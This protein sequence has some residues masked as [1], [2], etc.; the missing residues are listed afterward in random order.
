MASPCSRVAL[1]T[2]A[3]HVW[4]GQGGRCDGHETGRDLSHGHH[5]ARSSIT[6]VV[7]SNCHVVSGICILD[8]KNGFKAR[9]LRLRV[10]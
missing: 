10:A 3:P 1:F 4:V 8:V 2:F 9:A 5:E 6:I 7:L